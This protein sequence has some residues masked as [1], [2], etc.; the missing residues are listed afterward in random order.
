MQ[1]R[2]AKSF[3]GCLLLA[4]VAWQ[5]CTPVGSQPPP[6]PPPPPIPD[7]PAT[8]LVLAS[9]G[10]GALPGVNVVLNDA[11]GGYLATYVTDD[12]GIATINDVPSGA[13]ITVVQQNEGQYS[14][15]TIYGIEPEDALVVGRRAGRDWTYAGSMEVLLPPG[16]GS[17]NDYTLHSKCGEEWLGNDTSGAIDFFAYCEAGEFSV[18]ALAQDLPLSSFSIVSS[19]HTFIAGGTIDLT[20]SSWQVGSEFPVALT[21]LPPGLSYIAAEWAATEQGFKLGRG[22]ALDDLE[23]SPTAITLGVPSQY[24]GDGSAVLIDIHRSG[25]SDQFIREQRTAHRYDNTYPN[26]ALPM[27]SSPVFDFASQ[28]M[29]WSHQLP[30]ADA[31][32]FRGLLSWSTGPAEAPTYYNWTFIGPPTQTSMRVPTLPPD[33]GDLIPTYNDTSSDFCN[34]SGCPHIELIETDLAEGYRAMRQ[35]LDVDY[36]RLIDLHGNVSGLPPERRIR[37]SGASLD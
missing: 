34:Q 9:N 2:A 32:A 20:A 7:G 18:F 35:E 17:A 4:T 29:S 30:G 11:D 8:V 15:T 21:N 37:I 23:A 3:L 13:S 22:N 1:R 6:E 16:P 33:L 12:D 26:M 14:M 27:L 10:N 31:D 28:T 25:A 19:G 24:G 5:G 36:W